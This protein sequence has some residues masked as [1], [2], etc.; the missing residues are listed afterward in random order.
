MKAGARERKPSR[1]AQMTIYRCGSVEDGIGDRLEGKQ[2]LFAQILEQGQ[3]LVV[4]DSLNTLLSASGQEQP[5]AAQLEL[6]SVALGP[7][8]R[9]SALAEAVR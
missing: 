9:P 7:R 6:H 3:R 2:R 4:I 8:S 1:A 5:E